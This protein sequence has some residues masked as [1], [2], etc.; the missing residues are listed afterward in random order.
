MILLKYIFK[1]MKGIDYYVNYV[2]WHLSKSR[3]PIEDNKL[4]KTSGVKCEFFF[5][6]IESNYF[7]SNATILVKYNISMK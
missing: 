5:F 7:V 2:S 4:N 3:W 1:S 6:Q